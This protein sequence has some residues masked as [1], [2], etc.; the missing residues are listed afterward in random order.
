MPADRRVLVYRDH[1][2]R[3]VVFFK[4][5]IRFWRLFHITLAVVTVGLTLWHIEYALSLII[6]AVQKFGI[7]YLFPWP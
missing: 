4:S 1:R 7:G 6:P 5:M 2:N 3:L